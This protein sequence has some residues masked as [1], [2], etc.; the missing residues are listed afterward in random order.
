M[1]KE[2]SNLEKKDGNALLDISIIFLILFP[3][4]TILSLLQYWILAFV[5]KWKQ[6]Y[7]NI[8]LL[9]ESVFILLITLIINP[10]SNFATRINNVAK[11]ISNIHIW[12]SNLL[13]PYL[14]LSLIVMFV[15]TFIIYNYNI[16]KLKKDPTVKKLPGLFHDY[17]YNY[18]IFEKL[19]IKDLTTK[20]KEGKLYN[21]DFSPLGISEGKTF[22]GSKGNG[23][24]QYTDKIRLVKR[25]YSEADTGTLYLG[26]TG[27]GKT[28][29][30]LQNIFNDINTGRTVLLVDFKKGPEYPYLLSK[31][32][33]EL[34]IPFYHFVNGKPNTY[35]N[36]Y[37]KYQASY[38]PLGYG[39]I[40][41]LVD[42]LL[43][44]REWDSSSNVYKERTKTILN[45]LFYIKEHV[46]KDKT[47]NI[48]NWN[49]GGLYTVI[50]IL[51]DNNFALLIEQM[52]RQFQELEA[53]GKLTSIE[54]QQRKILIEFYNKIVDPREKEYHAQMTELHG[55]LSSMVMSNYG[56]WL[57]KSNATP[58][59]INLNELLISDKQ[60]I[61]LF[62][63]NQLEE[64]DFAKSFGNILLGDI[65]R[66]ASMKY[67]KGN[68]NEIG[69]YID[70]FQAVS[71][72]KIK[73]ILEKVR[74]S[75]FL[76]NLSIQ[77]LEQI[78]VS[79]PENGEAV[80][81]S[82]KDTINNFI[83][84][85]GSTGETAQMF[86]EIVGKVPMKEYSINYNQSPT[87]WERFFGPRKGSY[88][89]TEVINERYIVEPYQFQALSR[90]QKSN[91]YKS[92]GYYIT[93]ASSDENFS[94]VNRA[95]A[96]KLQFILS[97]EV[98]QPVPEEFITVFKK[99]TEMKKE[100]THKEL[101]KKA[102]E[103]ELGKKALEEEKSK[104]EEV[105]EEPTKLPK[106]KVAK[107]VPKSSK[108][109][110]SNKNT[111][112]KR[113]PKSIP[114]GNSTKKEN[115]S[116]KNRLPKRTL[117]TLN[118][119]KTNTSIS[120]L[121]TTNNNSTSKNIN[122]TSKIKTTTSKTKIKSIKRK[123]TKQEI[124]NIFS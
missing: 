50:S 87:L 15:G 12:T 109:I 52:E 96:Q 47:S 18:S 17:E 84:L 99:N 20:L 59:H 78:V 68:E 26:A 49:E 11:N 33:K 118:S 57:A 75:K 14:F 91:N 19:Y 54:T 122:T 7:S 39:T 93:K 114:S 102:L 69:L 89:Y 38:D 85:Y 1:N 103:E 71:P 107:K 25:N 95:T 116:K 73:S 5:L 105:K 82:I 112:S 83:V 22:I 97:D 76:T 46:D 36:P 4:S 100:T 3:F 53:V 42:I 111:T 48:I 56:P 79:S 41:S 67:D 65:S 81:N 120:K 28:K 55:I 121:T 30:F 24:V 72:L 90:P 80:L 119:S 61:I 40:S 94:T 37:C 13:V 29:V 124:D 88:R 51:K 62:Q 110:S 34:N 6:K 44:M 77:S 98:L 101:I 74:A 21:K 43:N 8:I 123:S 115:T 16:L 70:E 92:T 104:S 60:C 23:E 108:N 117:P 63:F 27:A 9:I 31:K 86:S 32:A 10:F 113:L 66:V 2:D 106:L 58:L 64:E 35:S 45:L